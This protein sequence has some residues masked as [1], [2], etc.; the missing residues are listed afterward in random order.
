MI[1]HYILKTK[2]ILLV[3]PLDHL[4]FPDSNVLVLINTEDLKLYLVQ[5]I[6]VPYNLRMSLCLTYL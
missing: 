3:H 2:L 5:R 1:K 4:L 6:I